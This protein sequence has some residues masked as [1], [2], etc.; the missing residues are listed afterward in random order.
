MATASKSSSIVGLRLSLVKRV[1]RCGFLP[2]LP[3][4]VPP[5]SG[6]GLT[7]VVDHRGRRRIALE[8][9]NFLLES[10]YVRGNLLHSLLQLPLDVQRLLQRTIA[11]GKLPLHQAAFRFRGNKAFAN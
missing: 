9:S 5:F 3:F 8:R 1:G 7:H 6:Y 4:P 11:R 10:L 2:L